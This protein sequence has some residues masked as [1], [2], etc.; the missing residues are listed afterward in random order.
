MK[1]VRK[2]VMTS[3]AILTLPVFAAEPP[4]ALFQN[5]EILEVVLTAPLFTLISER[6]EEK[7][8]DAVI[9]YR[10][11]DGT[12]KELNTG[13][14]TRGNF[15]HSN[16]DFP[17][18]TLNFSQS[19]AEGTPFENQDRLKMVV[20]CKDSG[21]Y[22]QSVLREYLAY[23]M[24]N[25]LTDQSFRVR[26]LQI[27]YVD[28]DERRSNLVRHAFFIEHKKR[29][30]HRLGRENVDV[31]QVEISAI[32]PDQV[33]LTSLFQFLIGNTDF[34]PIEGGYDECCHNYDLFGKDDDPLLSI[35]FDFDNSGL[36]SAPYAQPAEWVDIH[37]VRERAYLGYCVNNRLVEGSIARITQARDELYAL[38]AEQPG[39]ESS[40]R[41]NLARYM[42]EFFEIISDPSEVERQIINKCI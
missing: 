21:W 35:P 2:M 8:L 22:A 26:L 25:V 9:S 3:L 27:T 20:H 39:L 36:V 16:C 34:S 42:D 33:N 37:N 32:Q 31:E 17:P 1:V 7:Y 5:N 29:L 19:Q 28:S 6:P 12:W 14:R 18:L 4:D 13:V 38:V 30:A 40:V 10:D 23:R 15:R 11:V 24:L 41:D